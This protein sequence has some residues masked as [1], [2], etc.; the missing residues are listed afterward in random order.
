MVT[1]PPDRE[2]PGAD[3]MVEQILDDVEPVR[4]LPAR[5]RGLLLVGATAVVALGVG[6]GVAIVGL[7]AQPPAVPAPATPAPSTP[8]PA[9]PSGEPSAEPWEEVDL[10]DGNYAIVFDPAGRHHRPQGF[11]PFAIEYVGQVCGPGAEQ[12]KWSSRVGSGAW[13]PAER[14]ATVTPADIVACDQGIALVDLGTFATDPRPDFS[15]L[16]GDR[17]ALF[18]S[19][20][21]R[22]A[23]PDPKPVPTRTTVEA[24][25]SADPTT[26]PGETASPEG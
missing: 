10:G 3:R 13:H 15:V 23:S 24:P 12:A 1:L 19:E 8:A 6:G 16:L 2:L 18:S 5:R 11:S 20:S 26:R 7:T 21:E 17:V 4:P 14:M 25:S 22:V 9:G